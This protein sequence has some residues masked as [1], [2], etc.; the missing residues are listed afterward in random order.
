MQEAARVMIDGPPT[1]NRS[2]VAISSI[3]ATGVRPGLSA[4]AATKAAL[5]SLVRSAAAELASTGI[6][7]NAVSPGV[8]RTALFE[9]TW[10]THPDLF[11]R[12][13]RDVPM[14]RIGSLND[15]ASAVRFLCLPDARFITGAN[16]VVDG[17]ESLR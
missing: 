5:N 15:V 8:T 4:Y 13:V 11:E 16:L 17:G 2:I 12:R 10:K 14:G 9:A 6:R 7:V 3:R 1:D